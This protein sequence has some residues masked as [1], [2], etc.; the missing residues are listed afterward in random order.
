MGDDLIAQPAASVE[1][2][3]TAVPTAAA[4][5]RVVHDQARTWGVPENARDVAV[6]LTSEVVTN[7]LTHGHGQVTLRTLALPASGLRVEVDDDGAG[8]PAVCE[9]RLD[10][11]HGRGMA[12][13][14]MLAT[15]WGWLPR[16]GGKTVW[17]EVAP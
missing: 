10:N 1:R 17:F 11:E 14:E 15:R 4:A 16:A 6:L 8:Q 9:Q 13:V 5:R 3:W 12:M 2:M 7:G